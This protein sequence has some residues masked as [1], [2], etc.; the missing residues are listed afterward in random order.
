MNWEPPTVH[1]VGGS[2]VRTGSRPPARTESPGARRAALGGLDLAEV[3]SEDG[4][5][6]VAGVLRLW[7]PSVEGRS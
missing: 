4:S 2:H 3:T 7:W 6:E 1:P 5:V